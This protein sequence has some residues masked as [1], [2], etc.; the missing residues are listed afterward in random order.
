M[1]NTQEYSMTVP[2]LLRSRHVLISIAFAAVLALMF[3]FGSTTKFLRGSLL[4][5]RVLTLSDTNDDGVFS[6][7]E[8][9]RALTNMLRAFAT[10]DLAYD[11]NISGTVERED[12]RLLVRSIRAFLSAVCPNATIE[13]GEQCDDGN[14]TD[15]D[16]CTNLCKI[17]VA[18][19]AD[20]TCKKQDEQ[21]RSEHGG[22]LNV[23]TNITWSSLQTNM[24]NQQSALNL[25]DNLISNGFDD[26]SLPTA[27]Q[28]TDVAL[29][30]APEY[31]D[32]K[33]NQLFWSSSLSSGSGVIAN[34][35]N[36]SQ[37]IGNRNVSYPVVC[38]R[39]GI[40]G[41]GVREGTEQCDDGNEDNT[42]DC[43]D[44]CKSSVCGDGFVATDVEQCDDK[45]SV[46]TDACTTLCKIPVCGD[47][48]KQAEEQCD[49]GDSDETNTCTTLCKNPVCGD[50]FKQGSEQCDSGLQNGAQC[51]TESANIACQY[52]SSACILTMYSPPPVCGN[53][54]V[55]Y[56]ESCD[57]H[58]NV[59]QDDC[60]ATCNA[61][62]HYACVDYACTQVEG[63]GPNTC[64]E[65]ADSC[66]PSPNDGIQATMTFSK[67]PIITYEPAVTTIVI[68]PDKI[69]TGVAAD[70]ILNVLNRDIDD[71]FRDPRCTRV[72][73]TGTYPLFHLSCALG[74]INPATDITIVIPFTT[75]RCQ[76][77]TSAPSGIFDL[78]GS[79]LLRDS[80]ARPAD[81]PPLTPL[82][83]KFP[84]KCKPMPATMGRRDASCTA[85]FYG[86][87]S[88]DLYIEGTSTENPVTH[89]TYIFGQRTN[90]I[91]WF[92]YTPGNNVITSESMIPLPGLGFVSDARFDNLHSV[93]SF[94]FRSYDIL[95]GQLGNPAPL[96]LDPA[97]SQINGGACLSAFTPHAAL[98]VSV[99][100]IRD[101]N[102]WKR[103][104]YRP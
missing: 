79:L 69:R 16:S 53:G 45:N 73:D 67:N 25:C 81:A 71:S 64:G 37:F 21:F 65:V 8:M 95:R 88:N 7:R 26:W 4:D 103:C 49:D 54:I 32:F 35:S 86:F 58:N 33:T 72:N 17:S 6:L 100:A 97:T 51:T 93:V 76:G 1:Q 48:F 74:T 62:S 83:V 90:T 2:A 91:A 44:S 50:G 52:C 57:D 75:Y 98:P 70:I 19:N 61:E 104:F 56:G 27:I 42:D 13:P 84:Y 94:M 10:N 101:P 66:L 39:S 5:D 9:R 80:A 36:T 85:G 60:S 23:A 41:N 18:T 12:L 77:V 59:S 63:F 34:L 11:L 14:A 38:I 55:E 78:W 99:T 46:N 20:S 96:C 47:G 68:H 22:C 24:P 40:C 31:F 3:T 92:R 29:R 43:I 15:N 89:E 102:P 82:K 28:I 30:Y 87:S